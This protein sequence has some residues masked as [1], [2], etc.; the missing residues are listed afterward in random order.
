MRRI[1]RYVSP[2]G[3]RAPLTERAGAMMVKASNCKK[4]RLAIGEFEG[5]RWFEMKT[6]STDSGKYTNVFMAVEDRHVG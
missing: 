2:V 1:S 6:G 4:S 3:D 5:A